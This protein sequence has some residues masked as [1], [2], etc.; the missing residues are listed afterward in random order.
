V[1]K[2]GSYGVLGA[3][4]KDNEPS[5][6]FGAVGWYDNVHKSFWVF[7]GYGYVKIPGTCKMF[8]FYFIFKKIHSY[9]S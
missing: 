2:T 4:N 3:A 7:G 6:R 9:S 1:N 8:H 5:G